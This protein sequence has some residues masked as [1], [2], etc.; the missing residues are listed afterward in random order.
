MSDADQ[1]LAIRA[2]MSLIETV[3]PTEADTFRSVADYRK[4]QPQHSKDELAEN[5]ADRICWLYGAE[6]AVSGLPGIF[7]GLGTAVQ[8]AVETGAI[9]ADLVVMVRWMAGMTMGVGHIYGRDLGT[10]FNDEFLKVL[11]LWC[12][13]L[14]VG[15][16]ATK[17]VAN[18]I[19]VAQCKR[20]PG[21]VFKRINRRVGTTILTK[22]GT[23]RGGIA[24]GKLV[25]FGIGVLVGGGFNLATMKGF[26]HASIGYFKTDDAVLEMDE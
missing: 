14:T 17:R 15:K 3:K 19:A 13:A 8:I 18:K 25:P 6:G 11:G 2:V 22:Y 12:G 23:K 9:A 26:K 10:Q 21:E 20:I 24:V 5:W 16:E 4:A 7:P 1:S